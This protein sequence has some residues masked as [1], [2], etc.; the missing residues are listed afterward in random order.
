VV[1]K[2]TL[3]LLDQRN[4]ASCYCNLRDTEDMSWWSRI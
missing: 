1:N 4:S 2:Q 3:T